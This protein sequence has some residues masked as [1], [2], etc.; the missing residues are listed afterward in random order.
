[1]GKLSEQMEHDKEVAMIAQE[2]LYE[3]IADSIKKVNEAR[4]ATLELER[5][6]YPVTSTSINYMNRCL[7]DIE[8]LLK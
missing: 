1:M 7:D 2:S 5:E 6:L 8:E 4:M 3:N